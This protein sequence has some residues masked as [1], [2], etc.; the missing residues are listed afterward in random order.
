MS[1]VIKWL[2]KFDTEYNA[3]S[4]VLHIRK[5]M[6]VTEFVYLKKILE[7]YRYKISDIII[8]G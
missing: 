5:P 6:K 2:N 7:P 3:E 8:E 4:K 1:N